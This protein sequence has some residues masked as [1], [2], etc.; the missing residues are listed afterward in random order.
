[1]CN[2][3]QFEVVE[4]CLDVLFCERDFD[5]CLALRVC[6]ECGEREYFETSTKCKREPETIL[7]WRHAQGIVD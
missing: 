6:A 2:P 7:L 3:H 5:V 4:E 1:M